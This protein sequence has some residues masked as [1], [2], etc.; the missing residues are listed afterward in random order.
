[1]GAL[2]SESIETVY[3]GGSLEDWLKVE[4]A[5]DAN[6]MYYAES[7]YF[8]GEDGKYYE[9]T[10]LVIPGS[11]SVIGDYALGN[12]KKV[13]KI[14]I[15]EGVTEIGA[16][17]FFGFEALAQIYLPTSV[18]TVDYWWRND[19][20]SGELPKLYYA[21]GV[22]DWDKITIF[23]GD[24]QPYKSIIAKSTVHFYSEDKPAEEDLSLRLY[25]HL[26]SEGKTEVYNPELYEQ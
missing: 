23:G 10:E 9:P 15:S 24:S 8:M 4:F 20:Y 17:V 16:D 5:N 7:F 18:K 25:W 12:L 11:V 19:S 2:T 3:Y 1:M 6:P 14:I 21:G 13:T 22:E 26:T